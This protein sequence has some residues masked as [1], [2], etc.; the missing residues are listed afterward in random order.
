MNWTSSILK[1]SDL[2]KISLKIKNQVTDQ[3]KVFAM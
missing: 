1:T 2:P 3:E